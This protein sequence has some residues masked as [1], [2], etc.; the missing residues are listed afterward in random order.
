MIDINKVSFGYPGHGNL[1]SNLEFSLPQGNI[2]GLLGRNGSGKSTLIYLIAGLLRPR[3]GNILFMGDDTKKARAKD[4]EQHLYSSR[5][6]HTSE[7]QFQEIREALRSL[8][9]ALQRRN[10]QNLSF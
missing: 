4:F 7:I 8:L 2:Y 10:A 1:Y 3:K 9:S 6:I 5:R